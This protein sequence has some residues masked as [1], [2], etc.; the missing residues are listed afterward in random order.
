[1][2]LSQVAEAV[3]VGREQQ[4]MDP[5][6]HFR[7]VHDLLEL[8]SSFVRL[9]GTPPLGSPIQ[10]F[11]KQFDRQHVASD[12][13]LVLRL[14]HS[15]VKEYMLSDRSNIALLSTQ[16]LTPAIAYRSMVEVCLIYLKQFDDESLINDESLQRHDFLV[17]A[18]KQWHFHYD[19]MPA[20]EED[21][22][23][24]LLLSFIN[25]HYLGYA[26]RNWLNWSKVDTTFDGLV[27]QSPRPL[28]ALSFLGAHR[29][30]RAIVENAAEVH[31]TEDIIGESLGYASRKGHEAVVRV[32]LDAGAK[33]N[34]AGIIDASSL[35][36]ALWEATV[37]GHTEV[38]EL[39]ISKGANAESLDYNSVSRVAA[40]KGK[41]HT[42]KLF[43]DCTIA[44][45]NK[46]EV[47]YGALQAAIIAKQSSIVQYLMERS[48]EIGI[49]AREDL[50]FPTLQRAF[51]ERDDSTVQL[52]ISRAFGP[53]ARDIRRAK[54]KV[55]DTSWT[56]RTKLVILQ[57]LGAGIDDS[58]LEKNHERDYIP[59]GDAY[60]DNVVEI[61]D[62]IKETLLEE[63][64]LLEEEELME[65]TMDLLQRIRS[66]STVVSP[67]IQ[68][69]SDGVV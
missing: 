25:T 20:E 7:D 3:L 55:L 26:Y 10:S 61:E 41:V 57:I 16:R 52:L 49:T 19:D 28:A 54:L 39:L 59:I 8:C 40:R 48:V 18:A 23:V 42:V 38:I 11:R 46:A 12:A 34:R 30:V 33:L 2:T 64:K 17:Y 13:D 53:E 15:S 60:W 65:E 36:N 21:D 9:V 29:A 45:R 66:L 47:F 68:T 22:V 35:R 5:G 63:R 27:D 50:Y 24:D 6:D 14:A 67:S 1:M 44:D 69:G 37:R 31:V 58:L 51:F 56:P 4:S 43:L 32:L 62:T